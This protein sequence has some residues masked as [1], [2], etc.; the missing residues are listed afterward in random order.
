MY[1]SDGLLIAA[2]KRLVQSLTDPAL[3]PKMLATAF[4]P[5]CNGKKRKTRKKN[6]ELSDCVSTGLEWQTS[7]SPL[8]VRRLSCQHVIKCTCRISI[9]PQTKERNH[10]RTIRRDRLP[11]MRKRINKVLVKKV[12]Q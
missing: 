7:A 4:A 8:A 9:V 3:T 12:G 2:M 10:L 11:S 5:V 6:Q 1:L